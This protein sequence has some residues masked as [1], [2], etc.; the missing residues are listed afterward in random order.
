MR[1]TAP[2]PWF[3]PKVGAVRG[4][5]PPSLPR[6]TPHG[7][8]VVIADHHEVSALYSASGSR[9][10]GPLLRSHAATTRFAPV[11]LCHAILRVGHPGVAKPCAFRT[12]H[13]QHP[14]VQTC[15]DGHL[16]IGKSQCFGVAAASA[17]SPA[18]HLERFRL[19]RGARG[20]GRIPASTTYLRRIA[21]A[22]PRG[23]GFH[24]RP[25]CGFW[26]HGR[27]GP[28]DQLHGAYRVPDLHVG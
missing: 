3:D 18:P 15:S 11:P 6:G 27:S 17:G 25:A 12:A 24:R 14:C 8:D 9:P 13:G 1:Y 2:C 16:L 19:G 10:G 26:R 23:H 5:P 22:F 7:M 4:Y 21:R 28:R 20:H